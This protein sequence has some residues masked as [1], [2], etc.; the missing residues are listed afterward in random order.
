MAFLGAA[1]GIY[2]KH[3][4]L[5]SKTAKLLTFAVLGGIII[6]ITAKTIIFEVINDFCL[7][8]TAIIDFFEVKSG[9]ICIGITIGEVI[10]C[11]IH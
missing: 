9:R 11:H 5:N 10:L 1:G 6:T 4:F 7:E 2:F 8:N 3:F